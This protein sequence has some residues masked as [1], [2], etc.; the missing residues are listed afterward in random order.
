MRP[1]GEPADD[2]VGTFVPGHA[3]E[4]MW[5]MERIYAF[6]HRPE[7][8][9]QA[10]EAIRWHMEEG[11]DSEFGGL[12]LA[13]HA[14]GGKPAWHSPEAK[15]WWPATEALYGLLRAQEV[16]GEPWC[17]AWR[18]KMH[19]YMF[20]HYPNT[21]DGDW[22]QYLDRAGKPTVNLLPALGV[23]D[24]FHLPRSLIYSIKALQRLS[25]KKSQ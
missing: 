10:M 1:G 19:D 8:V 16:C 7:R 22:Y 12:F 24:P 11:W 20:T 14:R 2:D 17:M 18:R 3:I 25:E 21:Q 6:H 13:R 5:F 23:K 4:S 9:R 15:V